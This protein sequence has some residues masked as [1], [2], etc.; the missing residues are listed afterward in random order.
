M[1]TNILGIGIGIAN[2]IGF[3]KF[4]MGGIASLKPIAS[5]RCYDNTND[6]EDRDILQD[7]SGNGHDIQLYNF[8]FAGSSGY[9][10]YS[11]NYGSYTYA[12]SRAT[13]TIN[14]SS[15]HIT[16]VFNTVST[17]LYK[18]FTLNEK[19]EYTIRIKGLSEFGSDLRIGITDFYPIT[20]SEDGIYK[21]SLENNG[22]NLGTANLVGFNINKLGEC[23][24]IIE[25]IPEHKGALVSDGVDDY[26]LCEKPLGNV[27]TIIMLFDDVNLVTPGHLYNANSSVENGRIYAWKNLQG[28][29]SAGLPLSNTDYSNKLLVFRREAKSVTEPLYLFTQEDSYGFSTIVLYALEIYDRDLTDEEIAKVK[30]RMIAEYEEKTGN[31]YEEE[32]A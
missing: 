4:K 20:I 28:G 32:T 31:K 5:Y 29:L 25:Q 3:N 17:F 15:I 14:S 30:A 22:E 26:G 19:L 13:V 21:I 12:K 9:G 23:N 1:A 2:A 16:E 6:D 11:E 18:S 7:L 8:A 27:G 24:I 10:L